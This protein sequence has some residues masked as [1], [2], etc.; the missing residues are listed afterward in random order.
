VQVC[1]NVG[2]LSMALDDAR[3]LPVHVGGPKRRERLQQ[4]GLVTTQIGQA[5]RKRCEKEMN[6][7]TQER[8]DGQND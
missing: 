1:R 4:N 5:G 7:E 8:R 3:R 2:I 6:S